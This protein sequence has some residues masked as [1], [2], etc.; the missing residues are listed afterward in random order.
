MTRKEQIE[1]ASIGYQ[2][3]TRPMAIGG[4][5]FAE[6]IRRMNLNPSFIKG[7]EW[8]D[9]NPDEKMIAKYL[10]EKKGYPIDLNGNLPSFDETMKDA[11]KYLKYK[12]DKFIEKA[13]AWLSQQEELVGISF[14]KDFY[15]RFKKYMEE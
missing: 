5:V 11:E 15:E 6:E 13:C 1:E 8:A 14:E 9:E 4:D 3:S 12:Q 2:I 10:Y 7:A